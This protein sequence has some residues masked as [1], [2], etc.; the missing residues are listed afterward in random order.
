MK[1]RGKVI[2]RVEPEFEPGDGDGFDLAHRTKL[3]L[4]TFLS[5]AKECPV[6][7]PR[8]DQVRSAGG[9][10]TSEELAARSLRWIEREL[11][12][13]RPRLVITRRRAYVRHCGAT[14]AR[15]S[16]GAASTRGRSSTASTAMTWSTRTT[17]ASCGGDR[18][19]RGLDVLR[20]KAATGECRRRERSH[21]AA[22]PA[23][24]RL[25]VRD[26]VMA[27][28]NDRRCHIRRA[29][30]QSESPAGF[31]PSELAAKSTKF[32]SSARA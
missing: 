32:P 7:G 28:R 5:M 8:A 23:I 25:V 15:A 22:Q 12:L 2:V 18:A 16:F 3:A 27:T 1:V 30:L 31:F 20:E 24:R 17:P 4:R 9:V 21:R 11:V 29:I 14:S 6:G 13:A 26:D 19:S 10:S